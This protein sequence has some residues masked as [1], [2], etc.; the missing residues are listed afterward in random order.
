MKKVIIIVM[1][2]MSNL[3]Y[4]QSTEISIKELDSIEVGWVDFF[5]DYCLVNK[6]E[7]EVDN[8]AKYF[9]EIL[10]LE[11]KDEDLAAAN[12]AIML[13]RKLIPIIEVCYFSEFGALLP[14]KI[15]SDL[16]SA[17]YY[18]DAIIYGNEAIKRWE[19]IKSVKSNDKYINYRYYL[20]LLD[21]GIAFSNC[22]DTKQSHELLRNCIELTKGIKEYEGIYYQALIQEAQNYDIE[23]LFENALSIQKKVISSMQNV[24][25]VYKGNYFMTL[26]KSGRK[27]EAIQALE[28][29]LKIRQ[30]NGDTASF[31]YV[32]F[33]NNL[34]VCYTYKN[35]DKSILLLE[36]AIKTLKQ[37]GKTLD[38]YYAQFL[39][40]LAAYKSEKKLFQESYDIE[41]RACNIWKRIVE[42]NNPNRLTSLMRLSRWQYYTNRW[43]DAE[44]IIIHATDIEDQN[45]IYSMLN[46]K[47]V[48]INLW[49]VNKEWYLNL[50]PVFA[51][52]IKTDSL[53]IT[54][55]N[56]ALFSKGILLQTE[57]ILKELRDKNPHNASLY[58]ELQNLKQQL[59]KSCPVDQYDSLVKQITL[60]E[61]EYYNSIYSTEDYQKKMYTRWGDVQSKLSSKDIAIEFI[62]FKDDDGLIKYFALVLNKEL[63][64]PALV[65][66]FDESQLPGRNNAYTGHELSSLVWKP[67]EKYLDGVENI[68]FSPSGQLHVYA[69]ENAMHWSENTYMCDKY[70]IVRLSSTRELVLDEFSAPIKKA[71]VFGGIKYNMP[72]E[73]YISESRNYPAPKDDIEPVFAFNDKNDNKTGRG[74]GGEDLPWSK[75]EVKMLDSLLAN[76]G[77][78]CTLKDSIFATENAFKALAEKD[79]NIVHLSTHGYYLEKEEAEHKS[80]LDNFKFLQ[81]DNESQE[82][83][84]RATLSRSYLKLAGADNDKKDLPDDVNDGILTAY[85]ISR[86]DLR[87]VD[88]AVLAAC[89]SGL[90][91]IRGDEVFGLQR[92]FKK[93]GV[94]SILMSLCDVDDKETM[95]FMTEFYTNLIQHKMD[96][97][98]ALKKAKE[99]SREK[100][101]GSTTW[102][103]FILIDALY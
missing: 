62:S 5:L 73:A 52:Y 74:I 103:N 27:E 54:A 84:D 102:A 63:K 4:A 71:L 85:E 55:Y 96:K 1:V 42:E 92:G 18:V 14:S 17:G 22:Q 3:A 37:Q 11:N 75:K 81:G 67:M 53:N 51:Y 66:L 23:G 12:L 49:K 10:V 45:I 21:V 59:L 40:N 61:N 93:A 41:M 39:S 78:N 94:N 38:P 64:C 89:Q 34:S 72:L 101:K 98:T 32:I 69:I 15:C 29:M 57:L 46:P 79:K 19:K 26:F 77:V 86:L 31:E 44:P 20:T 58:S 16:L 91:D 28:E 13:Y 70:N 47:E 87:N 88:L 65:P 24:P 97:K 8:I 90:G 68:Y 33:L 83:E 50:I 36:E 99:T 82:D 2:V 76:N 60:L 9:V 7:E 95:F 35:I 43:K 48:R 6:D 25:D 100:Y 80:M 30:E 56:A